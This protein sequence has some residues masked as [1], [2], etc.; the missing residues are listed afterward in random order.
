MRSPGSGVVLCGHVGHSFLILF[1]ELAPQKDPPTVEEKDKK[2]TTAQPHM[3]STLPDLPLAALLPDL[4][5]AA[6]R[7]QPTSK[8][9]TSLHS[10]P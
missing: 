2:L 7:L 5:R 8:E 3:R 4:L 9:T 6:L 1:L 10:R